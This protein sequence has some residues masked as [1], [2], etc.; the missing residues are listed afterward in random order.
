MTVQHNIGLGIN[1]SYI[2]L[3]LRN[4]NFKAKILL[5]RNANVND[6]CKC[7]NK[8]ENIELV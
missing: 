8:I 6:E 1:A 7:D 4:V 3:C 2:Q 5:V